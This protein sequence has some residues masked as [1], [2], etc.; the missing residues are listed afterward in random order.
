MNLLPRTP[1]PIV[2]AYVA[3]AETIFAFT[4]AFYAAVMCFLLSPGSKFAHSTIMIRG[5]L[6]KTYRLVDLTV[7]LILS[8]ALAGIVAS[9]V[10]ANQ[11]V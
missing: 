6:F 5:R 10:N 3:V 4:C 7:F 2:T 8:V 9:I 1:K 11:N